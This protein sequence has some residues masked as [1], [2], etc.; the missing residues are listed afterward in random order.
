MILRLVPSIFTNLHVPNLLLGRLKL[1]SYTHPRW[2]LDEF[3]LN[4]WERFLR[5]P[6]WNK[7]RSCSVC[8][9]QSLGNN[10]LSE[11]Q[12][13]NLQWQDV[14]FRSGWYASLASSI[15]VALTKPFN[16]KLQ[17][18]LLLTYSPTFLS[19]L[20]MRIDCFI[21]Y[22]CKEAVDQLF[23][24][25][26]GKDKAH[27]PVSIWRINTLCWKVVQLFEVRIPVAMT[28]RK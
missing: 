12:N 27:P 1:K 2:S 3:F 23:L 13:K 5:D 21:F 24:R 15:L 19:T 25:L 28:T 18:K 9:I 6:C 10:G 14:K 16:P 8:P 11:G 7:R 4:P 22:Y 20:V 17:T 26:K